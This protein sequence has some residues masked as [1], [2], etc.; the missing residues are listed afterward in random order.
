MLILG[1]L[2]GHFGLAFWPFWARFWAIL[3]SF[4]EEKGSFFVISDHLVRFLFFFDHSGLVFCNF[5]PFGARF[6]SCWGRVF[7]FL[8]RW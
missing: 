8:D 4:L 1:S 2:L 5:G 3:G 6:S 7:A